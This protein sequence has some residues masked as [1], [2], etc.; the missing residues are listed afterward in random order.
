[1]PGS[2]SSPA[3]QPQPWQQM[4]VTIRKYIGAI[5]PGHKLPATVQNVRDRDTC[6]IKARNAS[7][8][9]ANHSFA[10]ASRLLEL[11]AALGT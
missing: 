8:V 6:V 1:M 3:D 7:R 10:A 11:G 5:P 2:I 9:V 4:K